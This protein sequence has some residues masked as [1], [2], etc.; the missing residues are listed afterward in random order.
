MDFG[1]DPTG[2][3]KA[4]WFLRRNSLVHAELFRAG[5]G[6]GDGSQCPAQK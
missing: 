2:K 1:T 5:S 3:G 6:A 4:L